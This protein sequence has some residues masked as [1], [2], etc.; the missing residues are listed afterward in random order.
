MQLCNLLAPDFVFDERYI[1]NYALHVS[2]NTLSET[3]H[4]VS[5]NSFQENWILDMNGIVGFFYAGDGVLHVGYVLVIL[6]HKELSNSGR[7]SMSVKGMYA[8]N[9]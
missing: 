7:P 8:T 2:I 9:V 4:L 3:A 5:K 6:L 1:L